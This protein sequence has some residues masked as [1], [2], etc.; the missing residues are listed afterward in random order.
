MMIGPAAYVRIVL[1]SI[2]FALVAVGP[3]ALLTPDTAATAFGIPAATA[4]ARAYL[5]ASAT[6]DVALGIWLLALI[7]L[8]AG[9]RLLAASVFAIA[10]V[11]VG[12]ALN[13]AVNAGHVAPA[14]V[15]HLAGVFVLLVLG[16]Y[17][18]LSGDSH[19][20]R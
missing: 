7:R 2:G 9:S 3:A 5:V 16:L 14:L 6:R 17:L 20:A 4:D 10:L 1:A 12:D 15:P 11:A 8:R 18:C 19:D 13:V